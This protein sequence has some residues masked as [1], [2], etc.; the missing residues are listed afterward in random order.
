[1]NSQNLPI[2]GPCPIDLDAIGFDRAAKQA[3]CAHCD[4]SVHNLSNMSRDEARA[5]LK[6]NAGQKLCV[7]YSRERDGTILFKAACDASEP[8]A[9]V[10]PLS[11]VRASARRAAVPAAAALGLAAALAACT[12]HGDETP[13]RPT[14]TKIE[15]HQPH[16][17]QPREPEQV[18]AGMMQ[19]VPEPVAPEMVDG[20][21]P[22]PEDIEQIEGQMKI[23][24]SAIPDEPCDKTKDGT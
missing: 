14:P 3:H 4:K 20:E 2:T 11:R 8:K 5:F 12:P 24:P 10:V 22:I 18:M 19:V 7:S 1:M 6:R 13:S 17:V 15:H 16:K 23:D 21:M 9:T